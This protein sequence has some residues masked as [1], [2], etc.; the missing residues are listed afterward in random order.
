MEKWFRRLADVPGIDYI[1]DTTVDRSKLPGHDAVAKVSRYVFDGRHHES[2]EWPSEGGNTGSSPAQAWK[3]QPREGESEAQTI[4]RELREA[5]ELPGT[6]S[7]YHFAIQGCSDELRRLARQEPWVLEEVERLCWVDVR[8]VSRYPKTITMEPITIEDEQLA[9]VARERRGS[10]QF[11]GVSAFHHL[12]A[13]YEGEGYLR[14][15][16]EVAKIGEQFEQLP[17]KVEEIEERLKRIESE[18]ANS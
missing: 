13:M 6:L 8:L 5:L 7:D 16:L 17:G 9:K 2:I 1:P 3:T 14:E 4:V 11:F 10:R 15:A 18:F 12:I